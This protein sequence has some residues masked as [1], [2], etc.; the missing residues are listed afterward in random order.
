MPDAYHALLH[1]L[2]VAGSMT[3]Q[4]TWSLILGFALSAIIEALV[5]KSTIAP[6]LPDDRP[7]SLATATGLRAASSGS[8]RAIVD[9]R[10]SASMIADRAK[11]RINDQVTCQ[12]IDPAIPNA[13]SSPCQKSLMPVS[14]GPSVLCRACVACL[15][16]VPCAGHRTSPELYPL[17][18]ST[19]KRRVRPGGSA[20]LQQPDL[21]GVGVG[22]GGDQPAADVREIVTD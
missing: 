12:V 7:R 20:F 1:A 9:L 15:R 8:N 4:V 13:W 22:E 11:P 3:W 18:V 14:S 16:A 5:R 21:A 2:Q 6:L 19:T 17:G 10:T